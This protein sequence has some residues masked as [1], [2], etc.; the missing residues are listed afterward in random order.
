VA[1]RR[2]AEKCSFLRLSVGESIRRLSVS[3]L[4]V[5]QASAKKCYQR[6]G[7]TSIRLPNLQFISAGLIAAAGN[8]LSHF[9]ALLIKACG[10]DAAERFVLARHALGH[11]LGRF[12]SHAN[13]SAGLVIGF[14]QIQ[15]YYR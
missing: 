1:C 13:Q 2:Q 4:P 8:L 11:D 3:D 6:V 14:G 10:P 7:H 15:V 5:F 9:G 12:Q